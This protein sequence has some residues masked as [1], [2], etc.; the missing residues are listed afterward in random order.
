MTS[1]PLS[2][3]F[4]LLLVATLLLATTGCSSRPAAAQRLFD[5]GEYQKVMDKYPDLEIARRARAKLADQLVA[6]KKY[7]VVL[8]SYA[9]TPAAFRA[10]TE[11]AQKMFDEG[12]YMALLDSFP[13][14]PLTVTAK[15]RLA[16]SLYAAGRLDSLVRRFS[17]TARGKQVRTEQAAAELVKIKK[18]KGAEK[19]KALED[20]MRTYSG[21]EAS[22]EAGQMLSKIREAESKTKR[23]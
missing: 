5:K 21:T 7:D 14:S 9:D 13:T 1:H 19:R 2:R 11:L 8:R 16:D 20:F 17:E 4:A 22:K 23:K 15:E 3:I 12:R 18:M 10:R 6:E